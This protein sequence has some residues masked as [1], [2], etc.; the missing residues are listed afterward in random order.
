M[1]DGQAD[2]QIM[3][4]YISRERDLEFNAE[5]HAEARA[6]RTCCSVRSW[7]DRMVDVYSSRQENTHVE[8]AFPLS[9]L[10][11]DQRREYGVK[12]PK[13]VPVEDCVL[14][15]GAFSDRG[16]VATARPFS[17][18]G[19]RF[20]HMTV[21]RAEF[22]GALQFALNQ[23]GK[24]YDAVGASW[25]LMVWP[26]APT[27][28]RWW[29]ASLTHAILKKAGMLTHY[30]LNTLDVDDIVAITKVS[31]RRNHGMTPRGRNLAKQSIAAKL[32]GGPAASTRNL[33]GE[34]MTDVVDA[35]DASCRHMASAVP[36][37]KPSDPSKKND[38]D[39]RPTALRTGGKRSK[40]GGGGRRNVTMHLT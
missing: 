24:P 31:G 17:N 32:F 40:R 6:G 14:A 12:I 7:K 27:R 34:L 19:Y 25:R 8:V 35:V 38:D 5:R 13:S 4:A 15:F 2:A 33:A 37:P 36:K 10:T 23:N 18:P 26:A 9:A 21:R 39:N 22:T 20:I 16:V 30:P 28:K 3:L 11:P 1:P 29:C